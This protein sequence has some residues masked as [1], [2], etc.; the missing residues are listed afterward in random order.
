MKTDRVLKGIL[1]AL[2][3]ASTFNLAWQV[4]R[5]VRATAARQ[6][7]YE[8]HGFIACK[9]GPSADESARFM[10][11]LGLSLAFFACPLGRRFGKVASLCGLLFASG[12][13]ALWWRYYFAL[14]ESSGAAEGVVPHLLYLYAAGWLDLCIA[15]CLPFV[16]VWQA[17]DAALSLIRFGATS[18]SPSR[19]RSFAARRPAG[20]AGR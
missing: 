11:E 15:S 13:Y 19:A 5:E 1:K 12:A 9:L 10:I 7:L 17:R 14:M 6:R 18:S 2:L 3:V 4:C 16:V 20:G 8:E